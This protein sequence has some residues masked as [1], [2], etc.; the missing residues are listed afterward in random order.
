MPLQNYKESVKQ[1]TETKIF[2]PLFLFE[3]K[4]KMLLCQFCKF[5]LCLPS[6]FM[7]KK[8]LLKQKC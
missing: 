2:P 6:I 7:L 5:F 3:I 4:Y 1:Q 8:E